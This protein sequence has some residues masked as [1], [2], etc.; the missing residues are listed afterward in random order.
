M[1][2]RDALPDDLRDELDLADRR[3]GA[4]VVAANDEAF[5]EKE[6][7]VQPHE[8]A[9][10]PHTFGHKGQ[11]YDGWET[12]RRREPGADWAV[13][14]LGAPGEV[15]AVVVD[16]SHF[17]GNYPPECEL[18][19]CWAPGWPSAAELGSDV[20][21]VPLVPRSPL[22]GDSRTVL[23]ASRPV[24]ATHVR[25]TIHPDGGVARLRVLGA[26]VPDPS[27]WAGVGLDL[28]AL[29][30]G[31]RVV[32]CS[33]RFY[34][35]ADQVIL[36][37]SATN[38]GDGWE[39][40]RRR[41]PGND[42][43]LLRLAGAG[44]VRVVELDTTHFVGNAPG[45]VRVTGCAG[46]PAAGS[47]WVELL[48]RT[49]LQPD[50]PHWFAVGDTSVVTHVRVDVYPDGGLARLRLLGHLTEEALAAAESRWQSRLGGGGKP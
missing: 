30:N 22:K 19:A 29:V 42:W 25:L 39:T 27:R 45:A 7:L 23:R 44:R 21:W 8:P 16:T 46:E 26:V 43:L 48:P 20:R 4:G 40:Q 9:F 32:D 28:V 34:S 35:P 50:T 11:V 2:W 6:N 38:M 15:S 41:G 14:R 13:V 5:A 37:G 18:Q 1:S 36:P 3:L 33:D 24:R 12:R 17:T 47:E 49:R 10:L 31:G